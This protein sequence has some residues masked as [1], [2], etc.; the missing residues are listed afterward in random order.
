MDMFP[1]AYRE[2]KETMEADAKNAEVDVPMF[3]CQLSF[4]GLPTYLHIFEPR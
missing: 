4:P 1:D 3:I 2:R